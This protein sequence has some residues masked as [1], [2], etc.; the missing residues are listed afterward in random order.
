MNDTEI[1]SAQLLRPVPVFGPLSPQLFLQIA[2]DL[3]VAVGI[4]DIAELVGVA[5][6]V[7]ELPFADSVVD[8]LVPVGADAVRCTES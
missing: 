2:K 5:V 3:L 4:H 1:T 7:E 6:E 8:E